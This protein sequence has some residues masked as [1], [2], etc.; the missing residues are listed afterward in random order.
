MRAAG[1]CDW[2]SRA[3]GH[4]GQA[5]FANR[6]VCVDESSGDADAET[7]VEKNGLDSSGG[8]KDSIKRFRVISVTLR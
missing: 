4:P 5:C 8:E 7:G 3:E 1:F 2:I 6:E